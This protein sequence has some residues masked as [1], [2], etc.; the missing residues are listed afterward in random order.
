MPFIQ[1]ED[2]ILSFRLRRSLRAKRLHMVVKEEVFEVVA[3][4]KTSNREILAFLKQYQGWMRKQVRQK[5]RTPSVTKMSWPADF[6]AGEY[7]PYRGR[8]LRLNVKFNDRA[9]IECH[10]DYL[11]IMVPWRHAFGGLSLYVKKQIWLW[12]QQEALNAIK[13]SIDALC[14][15]LGRWPR[16]YQLKKQKTRW[17][18]CGISGKIYL[19][20]LLILAPVGAL[21]YVVAHELCHLFHRNHGKR[22]WAKVAFCFPEY[23][24]QERW[25]SKQG[26]A[27]ISLSSF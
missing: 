3:P 10:E 19:N 11:T 9:L 8:W 16:G 12:Y 27:L 26:S 1:I 23:Q 17:G 24:Q 2:S 6:L 21:E 5:S 25:L 14:P 7:I 4:L 13:D 20:W 15:K 18:S 22:F